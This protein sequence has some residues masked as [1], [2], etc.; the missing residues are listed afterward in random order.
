M[1]WRFIP[2]YRKRRVETDEVRRTAIIDHERQAKLERDE[3]QKQTNHQEIIRALQ[4]VNEAQNAY[5]NDRR[6]ED[7]RQEA[8]ERRRFWLDVAGVVVAAAAALFLLAQQHTMQGQL[9]EMQANSTQIARASRPYLLFEPVTVTF[10][11]TIPQLSGTDAFPNNA[12]PIPGRPFV[13][14]FK[15]IN[16][17]A[18]PAIAFKAEYGLEFP[19]IMEY[20]FRTMIPENFS[21][22]YVVGSQKSSKEMRVPQIFSETTWNNLMGSGG[23]LYFSA[24]IFYNDVFGNEYKTPVCFHIDVPSGVL[25]PYELGPNCTNSRT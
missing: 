25:A 20:S 21:Y 5:A 1:R 15:F 9:D 12:P 17:G 14:I 13:F 23:K 16:Y 8:R 22:G 10:S 4:K 11:P 7:N 18:T 3:H 24:R 19:K 6:T 2:T